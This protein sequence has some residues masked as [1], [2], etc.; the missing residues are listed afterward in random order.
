MMRE[1]DK[2]DKEII[3]ILQKDARHPYTSIAQKLGVSEGTIRGRVNKMLEDHIFEFVAYVNPEKVGLHV[4]AII[5]ICTHMGYQEEVAQ[6]LSE[7]NEVRFVG[8]FSGPHDLIIQA[9]FPS[10]EKLVEFVNQK[11]SNINGISSASVSVEL[12]QYKDS[13]S[14][15]A[16][17]KEEEPILSI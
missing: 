9:C 6:K 12:K 11:L 17:E 14:Y 1:L 7:L 16:F 2:L 15:S 5:S 4:M 10:N 3:R 13:F 8:A